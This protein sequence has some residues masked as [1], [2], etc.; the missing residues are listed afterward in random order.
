MDGAISVQSE[1]GKGSTFTFTVIFAQAAELPPPAEPVQAASVALQPLRILLVEDNPANRFLLK[2]VLEKFEHQVTEAFDG[3]AALHV[4]LEDDGFDLIL[5]DVQMPRLDGYSLTRI[6]RVCEENSELD[7]EAAGKL[8]DGLLERLR[9][10]LY[11]RHRLIIA[12]TANAMAGDQEKCFAAG[13]DDYLT[14]PVNKEQ[15]T[16]TLQRWLA[17]T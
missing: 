2:V 10:H 12:M 5:S 9:A 16:A 8:E 15:L 7:A 4:L 1:P 14:K 3:L 17:A 13:M 6:I 11:G